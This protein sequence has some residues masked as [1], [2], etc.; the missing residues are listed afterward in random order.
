MEKINKKDINDN[1]IIADINLILFNM[2]KNASY[3]EQIRWVYIK[4][5]DL[6]S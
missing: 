5:G 2:P 4:L 1:N 6:F 3:I